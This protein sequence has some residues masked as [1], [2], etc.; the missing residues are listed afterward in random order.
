MRRVLAMLVIGLAVSLGAAICGASYLLLT[1]SG[2]RLV[3]RYAI[4]QYLTTGP[5]TFR[6]LSGTVLQGAI[7]HDVKIPALTRLLPGS[8]AD[9]ETVAMAPLPAMW[10][11]RPMFRIHALRLRPAKVAEELIAEDFEGTPDR[12]GVLFNVQL[13]GVKEFPPGSVLEM[14]RLELQFPVRPARIT[15]V[16]NGRLRMPYSEPIAFSGSQGPDGLDVHGYTKGLDVS[17]LLAVIAKR[18][19]WHGV[20]GI[21]HDADVTARG[22]L[23]E[24][25]LTGHGRVGALSRGDFSLAESPVTLRLTVRGLLADARTLSGEVGLWGGQVAARRTSVALERG[26]FI[27]TG[28]PT[29]PRF[30]VLGTST[31]EGTKIRVQVQGT[32]EH[33]EVGVDSEAAIS[34]DGLLAMLVTGK[35]WTGTREALDQGLVSS[36]LATDFLDYLV[37]GGRGSQLARYFGITDLAITYGTD[38]NSVGVETGIA[39]RLTVGVEVEP[40]RNESAPMA[41]GEASRATTP[42]NYKVG[43]GVKVTDSTSVEIEGQRAIVE[44]GKSAQPS[45]S[46]AQ[47]QT[48][49]V[50]DSVLLKLKKTF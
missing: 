26:K 44:S 29:S 1:T 6:D 37:F 48:P 39:D 16:H 35:R 2:A 41:P 13:N 22:V 5:A 45:D 7:A 32:K 43:A 24:I 42:Y 3:A 46:G 23:E 25:I 28:D 31:V 12:S 49:Q 36:E 9:A 14:Q 30:D 19:H 10:A 40:F 33:P 11:G 50:D 4:A 34:R 8:S 21:I 18:Q 15:A 20:A 17:E 27:F 47:S 38:T